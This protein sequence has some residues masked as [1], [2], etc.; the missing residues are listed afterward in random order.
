MLKENTGYVAATERA[1]L[2]K[3]TSI[4]GI[5]STKFNMPKINPSMLVSKYFGQ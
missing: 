3:I 1:L 2:S 4:S 5:T